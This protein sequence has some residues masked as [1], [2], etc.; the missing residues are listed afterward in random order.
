MI[1][2][3]ILEAISNGISALPTA[4]SVAQSSAPPAGGFASTLAAAQSI[5]TPSQI[6]T[7]EPEASG[8]S[9]A[10]NAGAATN[11]QVRLPASEIAQLR[12][13]LNSSPVAASTV[14]AVNVVV[15]GFIPA[16][17]SQI[18]SPPPQLNPLP[19]SFLQ[20]SP[21]PTL[22]AAV[23]TQTP[24]IAAAN[25]QSGLQ[26]AAYDTTTQ[27]A[28]V[29]YS[30]VSPA[31][32]SFGP[33]RGPGGI[34][35][36][37]TDLSTPAA[38]IPSVTT[39]EA[40]GDET[41]VVQSTQS[42]ARLAVTEGVDSGIALPNTAPG[43]LCNGIAGRSLSAEPTLLSERTQPPALKVAQPAAGAVS[44][45]VAA[46]NQMGSSPINGTG[47]GTAE[48]TPQRSHAVEPTVPGT[49]LLADANSEAGTAAAV[50]LSFATNLR[51]GQEDSANA[52]APDIAAVTAAPS[53]YSSVETRTGSPLA[54]TTTSQ[55]SASSVPNPSL[56][57]APGMAV[58]E[59]AAPRVSAAVASVSVR[60]AGAGANPRTSI[61]PAVLP[62]GSDSDN[63]SPL[64]SQT[65]FSVFFS[66]P[67]PGTE[68][69]ASA[70]PKMI[71]PVTSY[72]IR[73]GH[74]GVNASA[75]SPQASASASGTSQSNASQSN[76]SQTAAPPNTRD[77]LTATASGSLQATQP[78]RRDADLTTAS[79]QG[80]GLPAGA[81]PTPA[82]PTSAAA[83][84]LVSGPAATDSPLKPDQLPAT[85]AAPPASTVPAAAEALTAPVPGPVQVAQLVSRIGQSE[86]RIGMNTSAFGSVEVR[87]V[88]HANDVGL[89]IGSEKGDLRTLL[90][91]DM[92]AITNTL[93]QQNLRLNSVNFMQ[94]FA[95]SNH[96][97]GGGDSQQRSFVPA[98]APAN[99]VRTEATVN[100]APEPLPAREFGSGSS[101]SILA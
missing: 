23:Q 84:L 61:L 101:L 82:P 26:R 10:E 36:S 85:A 94:G 65:P 87:T 38:L 55:I 100:D 66:G 90:T 67:G 1:V 69:A 30:A 81:A 28:L 6:A 96:A 13:L 11:L 12:R 60:G 72:A 63:A 44:L 14:A 37:L 93:Q 89:V 27:S 34:A 99:S 9:V 2:I 54:G 25:V 74:T 68:S 78:S 46:G 45:D 4:S 24:E 47:L 5:S 16:T 52:V 79:A 64:S 56:Q 19:P 95:F 70:L 43:S 15:P 21:S 51:T 75:T 98:R 35:G 18:P 73:D 91:N 77:S 92:P 59:F 88:V 20:P 22:A 29:G 32:G 42:F 97:S 17:A 62:A 39:G 48:A 80:A 83:A 40:K 33:V 86:M 71:L 31:V 41:S 3:P 50:P 49:V 8:G 57:P 53:G 58:P 7:G 76:T